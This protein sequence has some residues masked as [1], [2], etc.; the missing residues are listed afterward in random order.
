LGTD[1]SEEDAAPICSVLQGYTVS[2]PGHNKKNPR[3][4]DLKVF[5]DTDNIIYFK[6]A[7]FIPCTETL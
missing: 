4:Q 1:V 5:Q 3:R 7:S 6:Q 2:Q